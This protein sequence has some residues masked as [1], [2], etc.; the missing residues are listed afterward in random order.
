M[1]FK[2]APHV[3]NLYE[4]AFPKANELWK[5][6][7]LPHV[8]SGDT[9]TM[10]QEVNRSIL[11]SGHAVFH[12]ELPKA[13][14]DV[15]AGNTLGNVEYDGI[16]ERIGPLG[17]TH[18]ITTLK[19]AF[20]KP[21]LLSHE[22]NHVL[23]MVEEFT[24][25]NKQSGLLNRQFERFL[26]ASNA[27]NFGEMRAAYQASEALGPGGTS[28]LMNRFKMEVGAYGN[29]SKYHSAMGAWNEAEV[30]NDEYQFSIHERALR[31]I[32]ALFAKSTPPADVLPIAPQHPIL[33]IWEGL[34]AKAN[35]LLNR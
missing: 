17:K 4:T 7:V 14:F 10:V 34:K 26:N 27:L 33:K 28:Y 16:A 24:P 29:A 32:N 1:P 25:L 20:S 6:H 31:Y 8:A 15:Y 11:S 12:R 9:K 30:S 21:T 19:T 18:L 22:L 3:V 35:T 5:T 13:R 2:A 23:Q